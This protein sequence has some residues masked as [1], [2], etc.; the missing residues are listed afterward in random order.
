MIDIAE[1]INNKS[2][3][4][5]GRVYYFD[6][7]GFPVDECEIYKIHY[8]CRKIVEACCVIEIP[9]GFRLGDSSPG[10]CFNLAGLSCIKNPIVKKSALPACE[11]EHPK[12]CEVVAGYEI[13]AA[14][15]VD[16]S[17]S[18][19]IRPING[20]CYPTHSNVCCSSIVS[21]NKIIS[22]SCSPK[23][24]NDKE[25]CID[26]TCAYFRA[27]LV[28]EDCTPYINV[29]MGVVLEYTGE[30]ECDEE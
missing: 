12:Q 13:R 2:N 15:E 4:H 27:I 11:C 25:P 16:F 22:Y 23:P 29:K 14:G 3:F 20:F 5:Y 6:K 26:W 17:I 30:C 18:F 8:E 19:P 28:K 21:V 9:R 24:C 10:M 1:D 7:S